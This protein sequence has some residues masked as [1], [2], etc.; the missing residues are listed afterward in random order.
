MSIV[1][2]HATALEVCDFVYGNS[3]SPSF[4]DAAELFYEEH[5]RYENPFITATSRSVISDIY[6]LTRQLCTVD[7]PKPLAMLYTLLRFRPPDGGSSNK[8]FQALQVWSEVGEI[9]ESES[10]DGHKKSIVEHTLNILFFPGLHTGSFGP[11][12]LH[13][14]S[15]A[16][17]SPFSFASPN[18]ACPTDT[19]L[20]H[21][22]QALHLS[23]YGQPP[24]DPSLPVPYTPLAIPSPLHFQLHILTRLS[25]NE[26]GRI[27]HH[28]DIW[29]VKDVIG[30]VP[31]M[32]LAQWIAGRIAARGVAWVSRAVMGRCGD[33]GDD[34]QMARKD[35]LASVEKAK[36]EEHV[37]N[38]KQLVVAPFE[39]SPAVAYIDKLRKHGSE[40]KADEEV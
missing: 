21:P 40:R 8:W 27:T 35:R 14:P 2:R 22:P 11:R 23:L 34:E 18:P 7:V 4:L 6:T 3:P 32:G 20:T 36:D 19:H 12:P 5:A 25:F 31:G 30:L 33:S 16:S 38:E 1:S 26:Q 10:F 24:S 28:R 37:A 13:P 29:D 39:K 17:D 15:S 9:S